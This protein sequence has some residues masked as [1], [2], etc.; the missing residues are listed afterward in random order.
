M[1]WTSTIALNG[2]V[3][4]SNA[5]LIP[6]AMGAFGTNVLIKHWK[7]APRVIRALHPAWTWV[8]FG[9]LAF[10]LSFERVQLG[11]ED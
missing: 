9:A 7:A 10:A 11:S 4:K 3:Y 1:S 5:N 2:A 6:Y 8:G